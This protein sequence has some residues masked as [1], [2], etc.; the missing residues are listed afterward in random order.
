M[1]D[2]VVPTALRDRGGLLVYRSTRNTAHA[3][4]LHP[5]PVLVEN[6]HRRGAATVVRDRGGEGPVSAYG[7]RTL[8][9]AVLLL[10]VNPMASHA[11]VRASYKTAVPMWPGAVKDEPAQRNK[12]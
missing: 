5:D 9:V 6:D 8:I 4:R 11:L 12:R 3:T 7:A 10:L 2:A 1:T